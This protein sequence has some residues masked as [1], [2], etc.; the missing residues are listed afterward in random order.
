MST[1]LKSIKPGYLS[2]PF[3][4]GEIEDG[5]AL[6]GNIALHYLATALDGALGYREVNILQ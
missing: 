4:R 6:I 2:S 1:C 5:W 3:S